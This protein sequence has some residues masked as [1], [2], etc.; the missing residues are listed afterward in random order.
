MGKGAFWVVL[1]VSIALVPPISIFFFTGASFNGCAPDVGAQSVAHAATK[2]RDEDAA[3][4]DETETPDKPTPKSVEGLTENQTHNAQ[5]IVNVGLGHKFPEKGMQVAVA[6]AMQESALGDAP[7]I[8]KP[9]GDGDAGIFQQRTLPGWYGSVEEVNDPAH[10]TR[11]F[12]LG[13]TVEKTVPGGAG[14][15][16][17]H[18]P[19]LKNIDGWEDMGVSEA[20]QAVQRSAYPGAYERHAAKAKRIVDAL[21][22]S[23]V[24][25]KG[26]GDDYE[27]PGAT[28]ECESD[29]EDPGGGGSNDG[30]YDDRDGKTKPG[31]W[32]GYDN[33]KMPKS[34]LDELSWAKGEYLRPD[35]AKD[36][37][38]LNKAFKKKFGSDIQVTDSYRDYAEQ[39]RLKNIKGKW[40]ATPGTSN[41]GWAMAVDLG[42]GINNF[43]TEQHEWMKRNASEYGWKH[44][45][46]AEPSG[47][48]PE[49]WHWEYW[50]YP[51]K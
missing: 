28:S 36:F 25:E 1:L 24:P 23:A 42:S 14:P 21:M 12:L 8:D 37:E 40:A 15:K 33:G 38:K 13:V 35:A 27:G 9:N 26:D 43:G 34:K 18:I 50:G 19:G 11:I 31:P 39:V 49:P 5:K 30:D 44:P 7:G 4:D 20:A 32:G 6:T 2:E 3:A 29:S 41:H 46:W 17:Y 48:L 45:D 10:G 51:K 47:S 22:D 16:G